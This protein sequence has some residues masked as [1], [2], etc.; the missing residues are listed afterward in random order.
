MIKTGVNE[1]EE[2]FLDKTLEKIEGEVSDKKGLT[3]SAGGD[4]KTGVIGWSQTKIDISVSVD[5][6]ETIKQ[7]DRPNLEN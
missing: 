6:E 2:K 5:G 3:K 4:I 1:E 7:I